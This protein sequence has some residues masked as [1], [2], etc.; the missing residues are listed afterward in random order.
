MPALI[1]ASSSSN[2]APGSAQLTVSTTAVAI[3]CGSRSSAGTY[4]VTTARPWRVPHRVPV[5][6]A[7][8]KMIGG[9]KDRGDPAG[10]GRSEQLRGG[11]RFVNQRGKHGFGLPRSRP[12]ECQYS[13]TNMNIAR[14]V[15]RGNVPGSQG[16]AGSEFGCAAWGVARDSAIPWLEDPVQ[17]GRRRCGVHGLAPQPVLM[18]PEQEEPGIRRECL[19]SPIAGRYSVP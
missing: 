1:F 7:E 16:T 13:W 9:H 3:S 15:L 18:P 8:L 10:G 4:S 2:A 14:P 19:W 17:P 11:I 6:V 12:H 5:G